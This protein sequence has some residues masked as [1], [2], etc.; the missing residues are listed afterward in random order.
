LGSRYYQ[1]EEKSETNILV[2]G[3]KEKTNDSTIP[4]LLRIKHTTFL[5]SLTI[6]SDL[7]NKQFRL[8]KL[9]FKTFTIDYFG[10]KILYIKMK[11][12][13][14]RIHWCKAENKKTN[15]TEVMKDQTDCIFN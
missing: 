11:R 2:D 9:H 4:K 1:N 10:L 13:V 8:L 5:I 6:L 12:K 15:N 3:R 14:R 7:S